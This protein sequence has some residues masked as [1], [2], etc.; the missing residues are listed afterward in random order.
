MLAAHAARSRQVPRAPAA[1]RHA[2]SVAAR[3]LAIAGLGASLRKVGRVAR[4]A[5]GAE[6]LPWLILVRVAGARWMGDPTRPVAHATRAREV[7]CEFVL[8]PQNPAASDLH[9]V[10]TYKSSWRSRPD[11]M[12][13]PRTLWPPPRARHGA[14][15]PHHDGSQTYIVR[16]APLRPAPRAQPSSINSIATLTSAGRRRRRA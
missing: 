4:R 14:S 10:C 8:W 12:R 6:R 1:A 7:F 11:C 2:S 16:T 9:N 3:T 15:L 5:C 13:P